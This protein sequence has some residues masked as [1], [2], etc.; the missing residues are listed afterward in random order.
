MSRIIVQVGGGLVRDVFKTGKGDPTEVVVVDLEAEQE[1]LN[2]DPD[3]VTTYEEESGREGQAII[4]DYGFS[5]LPKN[6]DVR[7]SVKAWKKNWKRK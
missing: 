2:S 3:R 4:Q 1:E 6:C 7:R 5:K